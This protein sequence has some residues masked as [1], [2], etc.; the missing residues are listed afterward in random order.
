MWVYPSM[1]QPHGSSQFRSYL[2]FF[3][4]FFQINLHRYWSKRDGDGEIVWGRTYFSI[5]Q[6]VFFFTHAMIF[7]G[8]SVDPSW[9]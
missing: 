2:H 7:S 9:N 5:I 1:G 4:S 6:S 8:S 3:L